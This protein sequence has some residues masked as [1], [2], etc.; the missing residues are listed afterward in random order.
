MILVQD[1][2]KK[3]YC[4]N[5][6]GDPLHVEKGYSHFNQKGQKDFLSKIT[7]YEP[8]ESG[9]VFQVET[10]RGRQA[11]VQIGFVG[12]TVFRFR[13]Y[14]EG[15]MPQRTNEVFSFRPHTGVKVQEE[16]DFILVKTER[17]TLTIRKCP[18][19]MVITLD[20]EELTR[21]QI[22]D[23]NVDQKYKAIP[24]GFTVDENGT[25]TD[26]FETYYMYCDEAFYGFGEKFTG[27]NKRGQKITVWQRDAQS[28]NSDI[29]YKGM[30]YFMSSSGY[31]ILLNTYT[32]TH[33]NMGAT[34]GVSYTME[35]EDPYLDY[36][37]FCNRDYRG[38][39]EDYTALSGRSEMIPRWAF[40]F[41]MSRMS[42]MTRAEVEEIVEQM[43]QFGM[44]D[45]YKRQAFGRAANFPMRSGCSSDIPRRM[46]MVLSA[47]GPAVTNVWDAGRFM[48]MKKRPGKPSPSTRSVQGCT[49]N[50][51]PEVHPSSG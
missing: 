41:W 25:V 11:L 46:W 13:M 37:M 20:G 39:L 26:T 24:V 12:E 32:R 29:S 4:P 9:A 10:F 38:L 48:E 1:T 36:Y 3:G 7:A 15:K 18:W 2:G 31:S 19:E 17:V 40:G 27:F 43:E 50:S 49:A 45:V 51:G 21:E 33:F 44:S 35:T 28:T 5:M 6:E 47:T 34:S 16:E 14:P 22:K 30:P 8:D 23:H 42:Y